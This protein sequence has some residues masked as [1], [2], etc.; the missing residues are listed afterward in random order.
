M[1]PNDD[2]TEQVAIVT[3][4]FGGIGLSV[5][6]RLSNDGAHIWLVDQKSP[7]NEANVKAHSQFGATLCDVTIEDDVKALV[8]EVHDKACS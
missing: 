7:A 8:K 1:K 6:Q 5:A 2:L 3:G 4:G